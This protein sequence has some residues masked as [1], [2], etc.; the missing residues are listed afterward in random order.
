MRKI[1][2]T[3]HLEGRVYQHELAIKTVQNQASANFGKPFIAGTLEVA[4]DEEGLNVIPVHFTYVAEFTNAGAKNATFTALSKIINEGKVWITDGKD[5]ATKV[6]VDTA[7]ALNDF[8]AQDDTLVSVK[9]NEGGFVTIVSELCDVSERNV[10]TTDMVITSITEQDVDEDRNIKE[11][12]VILRGAIFNFR[13]DVLPMEFYVKNENGMKYFKE[14]EVSNS[15]PI[16]TKVWGKINCNTV[17]IERKEESAFGEAAVTTYER[18]TKEW[19]VTG[20]AKVPYDFGGEDLTAEE[21]TKAMQN[22]EVYLADIKKKAD[23]WKAQKESASA[24]APAPA[25][26]PVA[27]GNFKF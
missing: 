9:R 21:L 24:S 12:Y 25:Q 4:V 1:T 19:V 6:K 23:E 17:I 27:A 26:K 14:L 11:P 22:R 3:T 7:L 13:N 16:F 18:K 15:E 20:T 2:N 8:Y 5:A 10:F